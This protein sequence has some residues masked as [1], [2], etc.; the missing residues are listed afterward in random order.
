M[1]PITTIKETRKAAMIV[2]AMA[3]MLWEVDM[4]LLS[5]FDKKGLD[6]IWHTLRT[7]NTSLENS[8]YAMEEKN[9]KLQTN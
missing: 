4:E 9:L 5:S 6:S 1:I 8:A 3:D 7:L 2:G